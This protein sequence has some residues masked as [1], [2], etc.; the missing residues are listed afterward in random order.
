MSFVSRKITAEVRIKIAHAMLPFF[1]MYPPQITDL[2]LQL[3]I[4]RSIEL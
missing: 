4:D 2:P 3:D 1:Q